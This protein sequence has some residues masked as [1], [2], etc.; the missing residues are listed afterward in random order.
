[1]Q[2]HA[3]GGIHFPARMGEVFIP[4]LVGFG[5]KAAERRIA[6]TLVAEIGSVVGVE[7]V[8]FADFVATERVDGLVGFVSV[9]D[10][11][12]VGDVLF[13]FGV[14]G[15]AVC[16]DFIIFKIPLVFI[17]GIVPF[18]CLFRVPTVQLVARTGDR[19]ARQRRGVYNKIACVFVKIVILNDGLLT[20][21][22][23]APFQIVDD[24][25]FSFKV[26]LVFATA[27]E[28]CY[29]TQSS[30]AY[31]QKQDCSFAHDI[32]SNFISKT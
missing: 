8:A 1:M 6:V 21:L 14:Q 3:D 7:L 23:N 10:F 27:C 19:L 29:K 12:G 17:S 2:E 15:D 16:G 31:Y 5:V 32:T 9:A 24:F 30:K 28:G 11:I 22:V 26:S 4:G 18:P 25:D 20:V 13:P